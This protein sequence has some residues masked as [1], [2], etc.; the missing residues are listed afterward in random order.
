[1]INYSQLQ[2]IGDPSKKNQLFAQRAGLALPTLESLFNAYQINTPLRMAHFIAQVFHES[3]ALRY[4][5]EIAS[6]AAYEGRKDLGNDQPGDGRRFKGRGYIQITG[7]SNYRAYGRYIEKSRGIIGFEQDLLQDPSILSQEPYCTDSA[8]WY[9]VM[10]KDKD[11]NNLNAL[12]DQD[13][14]IRITKLV[15]G[16]YNGIQDRLGYLGAAYRALNVSDPV[17]RIQ[18]HKAKMIELG[19]I[20]KK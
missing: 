3:A 14:F 11:E 17:G 19:I 12:A 15:N 8:G 10:R 7:R 5:E 2:I 13:R 16:G 9:W 1:M 18:A 4:N 20:P 6:G